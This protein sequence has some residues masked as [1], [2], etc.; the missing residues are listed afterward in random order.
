MPINGVCVIRIQKDGTKF[1]LLIGYCLN[2]ADLYNVLQPRMTIVNVG[3]RLQYVIWPRKIFG[4]TYL[5][6]L[7]WHSGAKAQC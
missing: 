1:F 2:L 4:H 3:I 5:T 6:L 7:P